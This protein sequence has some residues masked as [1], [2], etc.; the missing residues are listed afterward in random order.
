MDSVTPLCSSRR[1][2]SFRCVSKLLEVETGVKYG[3]ILYGCNILL[4]AVDWPIG[5]KDSHI[6]LLTCGRH[7]CSKCLPHTMPHKT[8][9]VPISSQGFFNPSFFFS[10]RSR[11]RV[12]FCSV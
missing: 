11:G 5:N 2:G 1:S 9:R 3:A 4:I 6:W 7:F 12:G 8:R 10:G